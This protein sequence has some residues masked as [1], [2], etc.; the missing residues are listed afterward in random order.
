MKELLEVLSR[1][2]DIIGNG[3]QELYEGDE[4]IMAEIDDLKTAVSGLVADQATFNAA[5]VQ[6][7]TDLSKTLADIQAKLGTPGISPA[8]VEAAAQAIAGVKT[9]VDSNT[10]TVQAND[11][12]LTDFDATLNPPAPT[13]PTA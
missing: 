12:T 4:K 10:A 5:Q 9:A 6:F 2:I 11:K 1:L 3:F 13:K 7:N 8:D